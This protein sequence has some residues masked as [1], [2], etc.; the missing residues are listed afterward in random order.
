MAGTS[1]L[2]STTEPSSRMKRSCAT[3]GTGFGFISNTHV[4]KGGTVEP[5]ARYQLLE[6]WRAPAAEWPEWPKYIER[7]TYTGSSVFTMVA[8]SALGMTSAAFNVMREFGSTRMSYGTCLPSVVRN[9][10]WATVGTG[11][12][13]CSANDTS[14][15]ER[16]LPSAKYQRRGSFGSAGAGGTSALAARACWS[17]TASDERGGTPRRTEAIA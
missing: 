1:S 8:N 11:F 10:K 17:V 12:G 7:S 6:V 9:R 16:V 4:S 2:R 14:N 13:F 3:V 5:S 15:G